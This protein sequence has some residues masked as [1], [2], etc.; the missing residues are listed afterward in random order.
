MQKNVPK[1]F[2]RAD[3][4]WRQ[5]LFKTSFLVADVGDERHVA[6]SLYSNGQLTLMKSA[7]A[8]DSSGKDL[9]TL[10]Y[11]LLESGNVLIV[12]MIDLIG[13]E[14]ADLSVSFVALTEGLLRLSL[15]LIIIHLTFLLLKL[16]L[17]MQNAV[18]RRADRRRSTSPQIWELPRSEKKMRERSCR[19]YRMSRIRLPEKPKSLRP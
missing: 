11:A 12:D 6:C 18:L 15:S 8:G 16:G 4:F 5:P 3:A 7:G 10:A 19:E 9:G 13:A 17:H 2:V 14:L 1:D